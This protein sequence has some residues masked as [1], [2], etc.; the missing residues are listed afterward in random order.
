MMTRMR[1]ILCTCDC[2]L[3]A[4]HNAMLTKVED[5]DL[6]HITLVHVAVQRIE[7]AKKYWTC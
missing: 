6:L 5:V 2:R 1:F 3:R 4:A 7:D